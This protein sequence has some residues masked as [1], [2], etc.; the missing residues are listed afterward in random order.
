MRTRDRIWRGILE[1]QAGMKT[2]DFERG[3]KGQAM[4]KAA[5]DD[6]FDT[7][8]ELHRAGIE[9]WKI[10]SPY[11]TGT[12]DSQRYIRTWER[13]QIALSKTCSR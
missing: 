5:L 10:T 4:V 1:I 7:R 8:M 12:Q 6:E 3:K 9:L 2:G 11:M 13:F